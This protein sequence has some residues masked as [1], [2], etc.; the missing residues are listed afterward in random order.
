MNMDC[1]LISELKGV[2]SVALRM[3]KEDVCSREDG[4]DE[5]DEG[6]GKYTGKWVRDD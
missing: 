4:G 5:E 3:V 2:G 6:D 1:S